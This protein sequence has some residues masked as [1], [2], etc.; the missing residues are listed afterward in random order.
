[1]APNGPNWTEI[2][3][4]PLQGGNKLTA[5]EVCSAIEDAY[6][7][8]AEESAKQRAT[9][10]KEYQIG[11]KATVRRELSQR[12][13]NTKGG[14]ST[15]EKC[16]ESTTDTPVKY[17]IAKGFENFALQGRSNYPAD[18]ARL[19]ETSIAVERALKE[20]KDA[21][22]TGLLATSAPK[23]QSSEEA[24]NTTDAKKISAE[25][26]R[27]LAEAQVAS[28]NNNL[29]LMNRICAEVTD[30]LVGI[31]LPL[32]T[33]KISSSSTESITSTGS[34]SSAEFNSSAESI[35]SV[36][37]SSSAG[38]SQSPADSTGT[39]NRGQK[40]KRPASIFTE[41]K[42]SN[43][44]R[45]V[46]ISWDEVRRKTRRAVESYFGTVLNKTDSEIYSDSDVDDTIWSIAFGPHWCDE[47]AK[48]NKQVQVNK[49]FDDWCKRNQKHEGNGKDKGKGKARE[50]TY[51]DKGRT[52]GDR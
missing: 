15:K 14:K 16:F 39:N 6:P 27:L 52:T 29:G 24:G 30:M 47:Q 25:A 26:N 19:I 36:G 3:A 5:N 13:F 4:K 40:R 49:T 41:M 22:A 9:G 46:N 17:Y 28:A 48:K 12:D 34:S 1:M 20:P 32:D 8:Y 42:H 10:K 37:S 18:L 44:D 51:G 45:T 21:S 31:P 35:T 2:V 50:E 43:G 38:P 23:T 33:P 7:E 11:W